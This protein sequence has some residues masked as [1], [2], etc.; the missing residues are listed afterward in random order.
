MEKWKKMGGNNLNTYIIEMSIYGMVMTAQSKT[1]IYWKC[2][3]PKSGLTHM[4]KNKL[5]SAMNSY[6]FHP[7][8][9][10][11]KPWLFCF[12]LFFK[13]L[14]LTESND[15]DNATIFLKISFVLLVVQFTV[16]RRKW[17]LHRCPSCGRLLLIYFLFCMK[18]VAAD[19]LEERREQEH[20]SKNNR[21]WQPVIWWTKNMVWKTMGGDMI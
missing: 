16:S 19:L 20:D 10:M 3:F 13:I 14:V 8:C 1:E 7:L 6:F 21:V 2:D 18:R 11:P 17:Q 15:I 4:T 9:Y 5:F 12:P